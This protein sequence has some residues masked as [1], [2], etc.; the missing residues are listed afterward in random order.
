VSAPD[1]AWPRWA[2]EPVEQVAPRQ[3]W[4]QEGR[5]AAESLD[6]AL[7][8]LLVLPV[9]H[10]GSTAVPGLPAKPILDLLATAADLTVA[11]EAAGRLAPG[12]WHYVPPELDGRPYERFFV[13]V[14]DD[15]RIAH[16]HLVPAGSPRREEMLRFRDLLRAQPRLAADYAVLKGSLA[17]AHRDDRERYSTAKRDFIADVLNAD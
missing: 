7:D 10:V 3:N 17:E 15:R 5:E 16:L 14:A 8:G 1:P 4:Q 11:E 2:T 6:T 9:E 13:R 12:G